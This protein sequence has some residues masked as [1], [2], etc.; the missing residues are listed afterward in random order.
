MTTHQ[1]PWPIQ[2]AAAIRVIA[3]SLCFDQEPPPIASLGKAKAAAAAVVDALAAA[4]MVD[5]ADQG[6]T[7]N[8]GH[9][10]GVAAAV[11]PDQDA[12]PLP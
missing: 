11:D 1:G 2:R 8:G 7:Q 5:V 3:S 6:G 4:G 10:S 12:L 9:P